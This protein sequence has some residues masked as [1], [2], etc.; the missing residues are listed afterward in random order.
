MTP[1]TPQHLTE[2]EKDIYQHCPDEWGQDL[3]RTISSLRSDLEEARWQNDK[4]K[5][6]AEGDLEKIE[7]TEAAL[8]GVRKDLGGLREVYLKVCVELTQERSLVSTLKDRTERLEAIAV[9]AR[10]CD[11]VFND[12]GDLTISFTASREDWLALHNRLIESYCILS[13][14]Q[15]EGEKREDTWEE[16]D[17]YPDPALG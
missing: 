15:P 9:A 10:K 11:P 16:P 17:D 5:L 1:D 6:E 13:P 12:N 14:V 2:R 7:A 4:F 3:C 8:E